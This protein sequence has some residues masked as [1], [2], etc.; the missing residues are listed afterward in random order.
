MGGR[1]Y[2]GLGRG[3]TGHE[4]R[5]VARARPLAGHFQQQRPRR[6]Q[7]HVDLA[8]L[9]LDAGQ[10][11]DGPAEG[12]RRALQGV[13]DDGVARRQ[14][15]AK[16]DGGQQRGEPDVGRA[17]GLAAL[18][19]RLPRHKDVA[20]DGVMAVAGPQPQRP[21]P[22]LHPLQ[23][24][25]AGQLLPHQHDTRLAAP[26]GAN[27]QVRQVMA[28]AA[29]RLMAVDE[30]PLAVGRRFRGRGRQPAARR[31]AHLRLAA[32]MVEQPAG[33]RL[34]HDPLVSVR[35]PTA[36]FALVAD[37]LVLHGSDQGG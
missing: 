17:L 35:P 10:R 2:G 24:R 30:Q 3:H 25:H 26:P 33:H 5:P 9:A 19:Q 6:A 4:R 12:A 8:D 14:R 28:A 32:Q 11:G 31:A 18:D 29:P 37:D 20:K 1:R 7:G 16:V 15:R 21:L 27:Q 23:A 34:L 22:R 36:R 13:A